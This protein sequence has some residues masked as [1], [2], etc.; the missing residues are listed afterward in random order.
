MKWTLHLPK[1]LPVLLSQ[2]L[3]DTG[4]MT[5]YLQQCAQES[6]EV[7]VLSEDWQQ[8]RYID[9]QD[10]QLL[11]LTE[12][13]AVKVRQVHL[14]VDKKAWIYGCTL[15]PASTLADE[16]TQLQGLGAKP[17]GQILF[18]DPSTK[19]H[20]IEFCEMT[21]QDKL[22]QQAVR[23]LSIQPHSLWARRCVFTIQTRLLLL[24]EVFLPAFKSAL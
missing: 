24:Y 13:E 1:E 3:A 19:R 20:P 11:K 14:L 22:Y 4:S 6:F 18:N 15:F 16:K 17:L 23:C 9:R 12:H 21:P 10:A 7:Q 8:S 2:R 5:K